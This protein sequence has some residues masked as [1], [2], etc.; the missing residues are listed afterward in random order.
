[1]DR[2]KF[3]GRIV[4]ST[5]PLFFLFR[6]PGSY[7]HSIRLQDLI[8]VASGSG[9]K[10]KRKKRRDKKGEKSI[11][12]VSFFFEVK[13]CLIKRCRD[14]TKSDA[15]PDPLSI[16]ACWDPS[17]SVLQGCPEKNPVEFLRHKNLLRVF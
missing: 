14:N 11:I 7:F 12:T 13:E 1:V 9:R 3:L 5:D 10:R 4:S 8:F 6:A 15:D 16:V 2:E 17:G